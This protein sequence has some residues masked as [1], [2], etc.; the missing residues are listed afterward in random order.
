MRNRL[1]RIRKDIEIDGRVRWEPPGRREYRPGSRYRT[2]C[3]YTER[4]NVVVVVSATTD[5]G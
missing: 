3:V 4:Q 5:D 2:H 1:G